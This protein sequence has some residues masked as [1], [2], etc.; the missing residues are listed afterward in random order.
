MADQAAAGG[1]EGLVGL[2]GGGGSGRAV[3]S[4]GGARWRC[5]RW[6]SGSGPGRSRAWCFRSAPTA[7]GGRYRLP[8]G[9]ARSPHGPSRPGSD[10]FRRPLFPPASGWNQRSRATT[11]SPPPIASGSAARRAAAPT[12][13]PAATLE[14]TPT[15]DPRPEPKLPRQLRPGRPGIQHKQDPAQRPPIRKPLPTRKAETPLPPGETT[16]PRPPTTRPPQPT[17]ASPP[18]PLPRST[19][20]TDVPRDQKPGPSIMKRPLRTP[21]H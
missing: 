14:P 16:A 3:V 4:F 18:A 20:V 13:Q 21:T 10:L 17:A 2:G 9:G 11:R 19:T 1:E 6:P 8:G 5:V 15:R 7:K 12:P